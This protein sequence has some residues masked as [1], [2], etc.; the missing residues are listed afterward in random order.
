MSKQKITPQELLFNLSQEFEEELE[1]LLGVW[2]YQTEAETLKAY[3]DLG[4]KN[5]PK[6]YK[7]MEKCKQ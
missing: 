4:I 3:N 5:I 7:L 6:L 2:C 1:Y